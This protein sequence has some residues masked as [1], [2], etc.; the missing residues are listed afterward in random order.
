MGGAC[1]WRHS[2]ALAFVH[3]RLRNPMTVVREHGRRAYRVLVA[4]PPTTR[5]IFCVLLGL[6]V[7]RVIALVLEV[8]GRPCLP[9]MRGHSGRARRASGTGMVRSSHSCQP[10]NGANAPGTMHFTDTHPE[11]PGTVPLFQVWTAICLGRWDESMVNLPWVVELRFV[12]HC[13]LRADA[14]SRIQRDQIHVRRLHA[15]VVAV[16][17]CPRRTRRDGGCLCRHR[18]C[19]RDHGSVAMDNRADTGA[20]PCWPWRWRSFA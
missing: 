14:P 18:L 16:S 4:M 12:G 1:Q 7:A 10:P 11:Y 20:T 8:C 2:P 9:T 6:T 13:V 15:V 5:A 19:S 3:L 17:H